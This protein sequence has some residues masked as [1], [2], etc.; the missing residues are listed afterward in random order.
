MI[1]FLFCPM[2]FIPTRAHIRLLPLLLGVWIATSGL[3]G[4]A[5]H[6]T[7][8]RRSTAELAQT[9]WFGPVIASE[10]AVLE[11]WSR[12]V[13]PPVVLNAADDR[14][15][16]SDSV[17]LVSWNVAVGGGDLETLVSDLRASYPDSALVLLLQEVY[18]EGPEVPASLIANAVVPGRLGGPRRPDAHDV[19]AIA[20][21]SRLNLYYVPSMR[22]GLPRLS[23][24][25]R[26]NAILASVPLTELSAIELPFE[27]QRRVAVAATAIGHSSTGAEWRIRFVSAHLDNM[28]GARRLWFAG[29]VFARAR[30]AR[31]LVDHV[32]GAE[33]AIIGGDFNTWFGFGDPAFRETRREFPDTEV[34]D[35][36]PTF[37][38]L[39]RLDH[40][41]FRLPDGWQARFARGA[42][43]Y[44]SDHWP[45]IATIRIG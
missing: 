19:E 22:N 35:T 39:L 26:G 43:A 45:L 20:E 15:R 27:R 11:R 6:H 40:L 16:P 31:A 1:E 36:R 12:A 23:S 18:R 17:V 28:V 21:R 32:R 41:F 37:H 5:A 14:A 34:T 38:N 8:A 42:H 13:G 24:E 29:G 44:G 7:L 2:T 9:A 30:Q 3:S 33:S 25:D 4:C 10:Q